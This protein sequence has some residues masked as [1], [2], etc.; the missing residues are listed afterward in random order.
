MRDGRADRSC[1][2]RCAV[3]REHPLKFAWMQFAVGEI[4]VKGRGELNMA[5]VVEASTV[6][7]PILG[8]TQELLD[9]SPKR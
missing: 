3:L 1:D 9:R 8:N 4:T 7:P 2:G 5:R 6:M